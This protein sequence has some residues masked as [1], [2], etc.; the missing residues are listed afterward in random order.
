MPCHSRL[1]SDCSDDVRPGKVQ[2]FPCRRHCPSLRL[3]VGGSPRDPLSRRRQCVRARR[4][5]SAADAGVGLGGV[6]G[7]PGDLSPFPDRDLGSRPR[8]RRPNP[9]SGSRD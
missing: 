6:S 9:S 8:R 2:A 7:V 3:P 5:S 4:S 1:A